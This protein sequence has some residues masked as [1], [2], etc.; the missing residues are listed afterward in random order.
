MP[1]KTPL[2]LV[3]PAENGPN[4]PY[5]LTGCGLEL[6]NK[7][8]R[9]YNLEDVGGLELLAQACRAAER[10]ESLR[11]QINSDGEVIRARGTVKD[12]PALKH[13]LANRAFVCRTLARLNLDME[14]V[15]ASVGRPGYGIGWKGN[16]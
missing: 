10:A 8:M 6:W 2:T 11:E 15:R 7:V 14:P 12:H 1:R 4:P 16:E 13:E 3:K 5:N 9:E